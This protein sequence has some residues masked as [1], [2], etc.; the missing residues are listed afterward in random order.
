MLIISHPDS[1]IAATAETA[2]CTLAQRLNKT[3]RS[4]T[5][6]PANIIA[7][8]LEDESMLF[9]CVPLKHRIIQAYLN[10]L[11]AIRMPYVFVPADTACD[12]SN[13]IVPVSMLEEE[14]EK[15]QFAAALGR[16]CNAHTT[17][18]CA[19]DYGSRAQHNADKIA[20]LLDKFSLPYNREKGQHDSFKIEYCWGTSPF[21][22][23]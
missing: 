10:A 17:L 15:A 5:L 3:I 23:S 11:R 13:T 8:E 16:F 12:F 7:T 21:P 19:N 20:L 14:V 2:L 4:N 1:P 6:L 22:S 18:L 9:L